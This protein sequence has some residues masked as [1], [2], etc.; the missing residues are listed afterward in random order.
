[1]IGGTMKQTVAR[2]RSTSVRY[3]TM[4]KR[5]ITICVAPRLGAP[6]MSRFMA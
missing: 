1:M 3:S 6:D 5:G 4:S 2:W